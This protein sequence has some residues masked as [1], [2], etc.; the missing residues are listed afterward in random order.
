MLIQKLSNKWLALGLAAHYL[1]RRQPFGGF[2]SEDLVKTLNAQIE[3]GR[4]LFAMEAAGENARVIGYFGWS[5]Y[6]HDEAER[7]AATGIPPAERVGDDGEVIWLM[8]AAAESRAAFFGLIR[9]TRAA[10]PTHRV[11]GIRHKAGQKVTFDQ[12]RSRDL[13]TD[14]AET[15]IFQG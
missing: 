4:Y 2:R 11:M 3:R 12:W 14:V 8:T 15:E 1:A 10:H 5:L 9:A 13:R 7:F 6:G